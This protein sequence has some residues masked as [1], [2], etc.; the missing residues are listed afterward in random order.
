MKIKQ[1]RL[2]KQK[3]ER[4]GERKRAIEWVVYLAS[5]HEV[6]SLSLKRGCSR[7]CS[8]ATFVGRKHFVSETHRAFSS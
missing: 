3:S 4:P 5:Y 8:S 6:S 7:R 1:F 2:V